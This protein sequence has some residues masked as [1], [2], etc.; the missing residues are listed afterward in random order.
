MFTVK[1]SASQEREREKIEK[2]VGERRFRRA[3]DTWSVK[4]IIQPDLVGVI[5]EIGQ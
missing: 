4:K 5:G 3:Q 2:I 1:S